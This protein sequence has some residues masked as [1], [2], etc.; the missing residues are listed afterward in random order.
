MASVGSGKGVTTEAR[1]ESEIEVEDILQPFDGGGGLIGENFDKVW[2]G[3]VTSRLECVVVELLDAVANR[4][5]YLSSCQSAVDTRSSFRRVATKEICLCVSSFGLLV[6]RK[7]RV[8][9]LSSKRTL[10]PFR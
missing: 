9:F 7:G 3:L 2:S 6:L 4:V 8:L 10:P 1:H 5:V